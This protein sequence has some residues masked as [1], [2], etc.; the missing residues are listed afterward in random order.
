MDPL[1]PET[2]PQVG[3]HD[4]DAQHAVRFVEQ[5]PDARVSQRAQVNAGELRVALGERS[6]AQDVGG[7][8]QPQPLGQADDRLGQA[9]AA[10]ARPDIERR[11]PGRGQHGPDLADGLVEGTGHGPQRPRPSGSSS[12]GPGRVGDR[13][14]NPV[15]RDLQVSRPLPADHVAQ[16]P[17]DDLRRRGGS[18]RIAA[19]T[20]T[21]RKICNWLS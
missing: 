7:D 20:V 12:Q 1:G 3:A 2:G 15:A 5:L 6:L 13:D 14:E 10:D 11:P 19:S 17:I 4:A 8:R 18:S 21:S 16:H 9:V